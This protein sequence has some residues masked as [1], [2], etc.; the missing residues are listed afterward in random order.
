MKTAD[1][2]KDGYDMRA[3]YDE[4]SQIL[5]M[6]LVPQ[7]R[8]RFP[9]GYAFPRYTGPGGRSEY[10]IDLAA[11][12]AIIVEQGGAWNEQGREPA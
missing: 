6:G 11:A 3:C 12:T 1:W 4:E 2:N 5:I 10:G 8:R 7:G 9:Q